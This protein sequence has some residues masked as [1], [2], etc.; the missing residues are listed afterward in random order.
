MSVES[1]LLPQTWFLNIIQYIYINVFLILCDIII[2]ITFAHFQKWY[3]FISKSNFWE[4]TA[5]KNVSSQWKDVSGELNTDLQ[6]NILSQSR[7]YLIS[8]WSL[9]TRNMMRIYL[10]GVAAQHASHSNSKIY[11]AV[12]LR[13]TSE[14][15]IVFPTEKQLQS[16][17]NS[18]VTFYRIFFFLWCQAKCN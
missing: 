18:F 16:Y 1:S 14:M 9:L 7:N 13:R 3:K 2:S 11:I 5:S 6:R 17:K 15:S 4:N 12:R 10:T 8:R